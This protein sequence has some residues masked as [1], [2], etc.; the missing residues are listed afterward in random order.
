MGL[1]GC[2][3]S[4]TLAELCFLQGSPW[5]P[6]SWPACG[7]W[8]CSAAPT[9]LKAFQMS[10]RWPEPWPPGLTP[11]NL[12]SSI[13]L[14]VRAAEYKGL[15]NS[16]TENQFQIVVKLEFTDWVGSSFALGKEQFKN[17]RH[18]EPV[19]QTR[20]PKFLSLSFLFPFKHKIL[21]Q[22]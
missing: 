22:L 11:K 20:F 2:S 12:N 3:T 16:R 1:G 5:S 21:T 19:K 8:R 17:K 13:I 6:R 9:E 15:R 18:A 10:P 4:G 14:E 7:W